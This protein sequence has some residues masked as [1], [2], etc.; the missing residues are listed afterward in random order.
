MALAYALPIT[1]VIGV[2]VA[3]LA[4]ACR[5]RKKAIAM[6]LDKLESDARDQGAE[7][8]KADNCGD[9]PLMVAASRGHTSVVS[10]LLQRGADRRLESVSGSW[11]GKTA[12]AI[13]VE[14]GHMDT[15]QVLAGYGTHGYRAGVG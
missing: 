7:I 13:A 1:L 3:G 5:A 8:D 9:T 10:W 11:S 4:V 6:A 2:I 12:L 14:R 15:V